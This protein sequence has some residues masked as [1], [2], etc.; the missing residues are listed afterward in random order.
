MPAPGAQ[1]PCRAFP[2]WVLAALAEPPAKRLLQHLG[3]GD[4]AAPKPGSVA[5]PSLLPNLAMVSAAHG[6]ALSSQEH[7]A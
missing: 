4:V 5:F 7:P 6:E 2:L 3:S 1:Q